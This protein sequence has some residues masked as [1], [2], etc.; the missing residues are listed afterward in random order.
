MAALIATATAAIFA[1]LAFRKRAKQVEILESDRHRELASNF[2]AWI[3]SEIELLKFEVHYL[4]A[5]V[6][7]V[8]DVLLRLQVDGEPPNPIALGSVGPMN[9]PKVSH[10]A[11]S[12]L[13]RMASNAAQRNPTTGNNSIDEFRIATDGLASVELEFTDANGQRWLRKGNGELTASSITKTAL[14]KQQD[15]SRAAMESTTN[16]LYQGR[17]PHHSKHNRFGAEQASTPGR[18]T[19]EPSGT[20]VPYC[21]IAR[22][23]APN[24]VNSIETLPPHKRRLQS[25]HCRLGTRERRP[26]QTV[27][28]ATH[29]ETEQL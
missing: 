13:K 19:N 10:L 1:G 2:G 28:V 9:N 17:H 25:D 3:H 22:I 4:N 15:P 8:Y 5:G 29:G 16:F 20:F 23:L 11:T 12:A 21:E 18:V 6:Q 7:P 26:C 24:R 14:R 27:S